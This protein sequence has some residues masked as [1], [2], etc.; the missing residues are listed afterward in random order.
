MTSLNNKNGKN[1]KVQKK[2]TF[3][4]EFELFTLDKSGKISNDADAL[5][6]NVR[7]KFPQINISKEC[8]KNMVEIRS[9]PDSRIPN[10]MLKMLEDF[11]AVLHEAEMQNL[12]LYPYGTY[13]GEFS[14]KLNS[15]DSY[16]VKEKVL[17][18]KRFEIA[19]RCVGMHC[20]YSLPKG[21]FDFSNKI[22]KLLDN[23]KNKGSLGNMYNLFIA[24][25]P[26]LTTFAQSS[27]FYQGKY[28]GK[29]S[30]VIVY[31][32]G[33]LLGYPE[34]LYANYPEFGALQP[35][36]LT[37]IDLIEIIQKQF[38]LWNSIINKIDVNL[39]AFTKHG[40]ILDT[41]WNP[42]K[43]NAVGTM[44]QRGMDMN[45]PSITVAIATL[46]R[47]ISTA[48]HT[49]FLGVEPS[50]SAIKQ[51]FR[52][53]NDTIYI[54]PHRYVRERLQ[55]KSAYN[56]MEDLAVYSYCVNLLKLGEHFISKESIP[57][58]K[59]LDAM[60]ERR[61]TVSDEIIDYAK[62]LGLEINAKIPDDKAAEL[63]LNISKDL[64]KDIVL[65]KQSLINVEPQ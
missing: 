50:D 3:G 27:P 23:S 18:K 34:G 38:Y 58:L 32:G 55:Y 62:K 45:R 63:A 17:G 47:A 7:N 52:L 11:E 37:H 10:S 57:L 40:S 6:K 14:P 56:G 19:A 4:V 28:L 46:V 35:Y 1:D 21:V 61:K 39:S 24:M 59:P 16:K 9:T 2:V 8:G 60:L 42:V 44:E 43:V 22:L 29:D 33:N 15:D 51:P 31:R 53:E 13:P 48:V 41:A 20:H 36:K 64:F 12:V 5:I 30:R 26:A 49:K 25:D 65:T 54:P